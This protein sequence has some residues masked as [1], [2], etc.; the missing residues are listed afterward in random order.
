[1]TDHDGNRRRPAPTTFQPEQ[2]APGRRF[3]R[4]ALIAGAVTAAG[5]AGAGALALAK[6]GPDRNDPANGGTSSVTTPPAAAPQIAMQAPAVVT[7]SRQQVANLPEGQ[8]LITSPRLPLFG[9]GEND[10]PG[11]L[12]G[13][14]TDWNDV[15]SPVS[16]AVIPVALEGSVPEGMTPAETFASYDELADYLAGNPGAVALA[17]VGELDFRANVLSVSGFDPLRNQD[18]E[19]AP[20]RLAFV[21][22]IVPGRNV[23]A[24][25][26]Y[27]GDWV[28]PF[29]KIAPELQSYDAV[30]AN[31]E[32]NVSSNIASPTDAHTFSFIADPQIL[33]G[34]VYAGIDA[35]SLANNHSVWNNDGWGL[36][37]FND[38][39][40]ALD[41]YEI[42]YF[43]AG[44]DLS[45]ASAPWVVETGGI[46]IAIIGIDGV[47]AN[48][49]QTAGVLADYVGATNDGGGTNPF[50]TDQFTADIAALAESY[51]VVIP[52]FHMGVEYVPVPP[53]WALTGARAAIDAGATMAVTNH[54]HLIQGMETYAGKPIVY[55]V[56]N[57]VFDQMF[58]NEVRTGTV[59]EIVLQNGRVA[60][61]RPKGVEIVDFHQPRLMSAGEHASLMDRF[62]QSADLIAQR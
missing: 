60:G 36:S 55:S 27:Y 10:L 33:E 26:Q 1:M 57:F 45:H 59:L 37:A 5:V 31:L 18:G 8:A 9:V 17:P 48:Q 35:V 11:L 24:K 56:G 7:A 13:E 25:I 22:D 39:R 16:I 51:D 41:S 49:E 4:R 12:T 29:R 19:G 23:S 2:A 62:W 14:T 40:A 32:G 6:T 38:T 28:R 53:D 61:L 43:G 54:P 21:G 30:I 52:Y 44:D 42:P 15:G 34:L 47:T 58:S 20:V 3:D 46:R 50:V